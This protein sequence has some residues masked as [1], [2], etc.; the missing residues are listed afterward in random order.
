MKPDPAGTDG[1]AWQ[2]VLD[3]LAAA[4]GL[5]GSERPGCPLRV[6]TAGRVC[7]LTSYERS[8]CPT[9]LLTLIVVS[10]TDV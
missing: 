5:T 9:S 4:N 1:R 10:D 8:D 3:A 6:A 2:G 7:R